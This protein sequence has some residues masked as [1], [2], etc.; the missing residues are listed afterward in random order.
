[1]L[2]DLSSAPGSGKLMTR[3]RIYRWSPE[4]GLAVEVLPL[5]RLEPTGTLSGQFVEGRNVGSILGQP[6]GD[7]KPDPAGDFLFQPGRGGPRMDKATNPGPRFT[8]RYQQSAHFGEV[9]AYFHVDR[10]AAYLDGL[11]GSLGAPPLP[12]VRVLVCAHDSQREIGGVR[13]GIV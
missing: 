10:I 4:G 13:D 1:A 5:P 3:G 2:R 6:M 7:A 9:N 12:R 8:W 11:L